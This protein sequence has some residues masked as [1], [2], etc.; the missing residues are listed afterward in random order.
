M[1]FW[2]TARNAAADQYGR[3]HFERY[4]RRAKIARWTIGV[5]SI[6]LVL[7]I[8]AAAQGSLGG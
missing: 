7:L 8:L 2:K 6:I 3:K 5:G 1:T 4:A